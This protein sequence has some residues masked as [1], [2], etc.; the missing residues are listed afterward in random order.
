MATEVS[1]LKIRCKAAKLDHD[2]HVALVMKREKLSKPDAIVMAYLD[3]PMGLHD[4][5]NP[6]KPSDPTK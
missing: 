1:A 4:R 3:G 2:L 5:L 6:P